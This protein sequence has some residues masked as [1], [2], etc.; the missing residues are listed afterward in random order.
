MACRNRGARMNSPVQPS[1]RPLGA[2]IARAGT[3][4]TT[5]TSA[6]PV[7]PPLA[8]H[9]TERSACPPFSPIGASLFGQLAPKPAPQ[10]GTVG[11]LNP[12]PN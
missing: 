4:G 10:P 6:A 1:N 5:G 11:Q 3:H 2:S 8:A 9:H 7:A 12:Q